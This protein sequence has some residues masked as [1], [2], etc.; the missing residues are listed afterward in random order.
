MFSLK[1]LCVDVWGW[2]SMGK[3]SGL[4]QPLQLCRNCHC[5]RHSPLS[6]PGPPS[7]CMSLCPTPEGFSLDPGGVLRPLPQ[8]LLC[9]HLDS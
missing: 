7:A 8:F 6:T 4:E 5:P 9:P 2:W 1:A 3:V